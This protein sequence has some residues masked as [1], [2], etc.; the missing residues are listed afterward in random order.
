MINN[1]YRYSSIFF[2]TLFI[3]LGIG[4]LLKKFFQIQFDFF[5]YSTCFAI[6]VLLLGFSFLNLSKLIKQLLIGMVGLFLSLIILMFINSIQVSF[7]SFTNNLSN[8]NDIHYDCEDCYIFNTFVENANL[9][10]N[11]SLIDLEI[12]DIKTS[13]LKLNNI[14]EDAF[15]VTFDSLSHSYNVQAET[16]NISQDLS[17]SMGKIQLNDSTNWNFKANIST[18]N[19]KANLSNIKLSKLF[20]NST[21]SEIQLE[22]GNKAP[23]VDILLESDAS[24]VTIKLPYNAYCELSS[25]IPIE[26]FHIHGFKKEYSGFYTYGDSLNSSSKIKITLTGSLSDFSITRQK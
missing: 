14:G 5:S 3:S 6:T 26:D 12:T 24:S 1:K 23:I 13:T 16:K 15:R 22:I 2:G 19:L 21:D 17:Y 8:Y 7:S 4:L 20:L 10:L 9:N 11:G 25:N 18:S